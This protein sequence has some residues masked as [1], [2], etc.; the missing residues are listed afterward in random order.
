MA[1]APTALTGEGRELLSP[2]SSSLPLLP[3]LLK[4]VS[5]CSPLLCLSLLDEDVSMQEQR[6]IFSAGMHY[7]VVWVNELP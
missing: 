1:A 7:A 6:Y 2:V 3:V 4:G 5:P